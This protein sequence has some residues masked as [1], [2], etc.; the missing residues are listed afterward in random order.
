LL[1]FFF[2][3]GAEIN[4]ALVSLNTL[5][6]PLLVAR[7]LRNRIAILMNLHA[8]L[9]DLPEVPKLLLFSV[10]SVLPVAVLSISFSRRCVWGNIALGFL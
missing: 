5:L 1:V 9:L 2:N 10:V 7:R 8:Q 6:Q 3:G 4:P